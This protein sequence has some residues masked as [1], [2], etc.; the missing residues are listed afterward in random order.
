MF[1]GVCIVEVDR[2]GTISFQLPV[3]CCCQVVLFFWEDDS[4]LIPLCTEE[5]YIYYFA[6]VK[7]TFLEE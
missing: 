6:G 4:S 1:I 2:V 5:G 7:F 3:V